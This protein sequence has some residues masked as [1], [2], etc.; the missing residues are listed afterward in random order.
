[1][2]LWFCLETV[3]ALGCK[4]IYISVENIH[5]HAIIWKASLQLVYLGLF[6]PQNYPV[7]YFLP[8]TVL[9]SLSLVKTTRQDDDCLHG[10]VVGMTLSLSKISVSQSLDTSEYVSTYNSH[11]LLSNF[12]TQKAMI[13]TE[14]S[15]KRKYK[16]DPNLRSL[17]CSHMFLRMWGQE[18]CVCVR[19]RACTRACVCDLKPQHP[20]ASSQ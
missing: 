1:M 15:Y 7:H 17:W 19:A 13:S 3:L 11:K 10:G 9:D 20:A 4:M 8:L 14:G 6:D 12:I 2:I 5:T 16:G 18:V